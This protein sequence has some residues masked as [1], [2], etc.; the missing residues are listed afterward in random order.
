M[1]P[2]QVRHAL[3]AAQP[4][5]HAAQGPVRPRQQDGE[6]ALPAPRARCVGPG[7]PPNR[8]ARHPRL[9]DA[10]RP[11]WQLPEETEFAA[12]WAGLANVLRSFEESFEDSLVLAQ[13]ADALCDVEVLVARGESV[14][15]CQY[16]SER[17]Q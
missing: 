9:Q 16:S 5:L 12:P 4:H 1:T 10:R 17:A 13:G 2:P 6:A 3:P 8:P 15:N 7:G 11:M 14:I